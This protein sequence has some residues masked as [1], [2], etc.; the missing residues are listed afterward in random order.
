MIFDEKENLTE[1]SKIWEYLHEKE[2][3]IVETA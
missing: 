2:L 3:N 1:F